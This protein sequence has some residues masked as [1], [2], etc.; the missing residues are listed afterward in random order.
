[1]RKKFCNQWFKCLS[2]EKD[3]K[4]IKSEEIVNQQHKWFRT[5]ETLHTLSDHTQI[6]IQR[7]GRNRRKKRKE[8]R[9]ISTGRFFNRISYDI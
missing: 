8:W 2:K 5:K 9:I 4:I 6:Y 3:F 1:M 7:T